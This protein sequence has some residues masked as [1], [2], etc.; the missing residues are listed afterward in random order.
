VEATLS[1]EIQKIRQESREER[2]R[3]AEEMKAAKAREEALKRM[4]LTLQV[5]NPEAKLENPS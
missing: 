2:H 3:H 4:V 1:A 5:N